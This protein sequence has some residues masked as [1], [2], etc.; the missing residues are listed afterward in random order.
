MNEWKIIVDNF[1]W[2]EYIIE[3]YYNKNDALIKYLDN[4]NLM[5]TDLAVQAP[6]YNMSYDVES[7]LEKLN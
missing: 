7:F 1:K 6:T 3:N 2:L 5:K 4:E